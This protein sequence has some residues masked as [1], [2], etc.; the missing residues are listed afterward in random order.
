MSSNLPRIEYLLSDTYT[1]IQNPLHAEKDPDAYAET[2][3]SRL[4][5]ILSYGEPEE[6]RQFQRCE[7]IGIRGREEALSRHVLLL[8]EQWHDRHRKLLE[9]AGVFNGVFVNYALRTEKGKN[10]DPFF[11][12]ETDGGL[13]VVASPLSALSAIRPHVVSLTEF[14]NTGNGLFED[15]S[16]FRSAHTHNLLRRNTPYLLLPRNPADIPVDSSEWKWLVQFVDI[17][18]NLVTGGGEAEHISRLI[19]AA[20]NAHRAVR[21]TLGDRTLQGEA[22]QSLAEATPGV[23]SIYPNNGNVDIVRKWRHGETAEETAGKSAYA[24][25][26]RP[27]ELKTPVKVEFGSH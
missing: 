27:P 13:R 4:H 24:A 19:A 18:G 6:L 10:G 22:A 15:E 5:D 20:R 11:V 8:M 17:F 9:G 26:G 2:D 23:I 3:L 12:A 14:P 25:F 16:Q 7:K 21:I 1:G